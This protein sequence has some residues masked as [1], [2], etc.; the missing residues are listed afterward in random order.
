MLQ[1]FLAI[2]LLIVS[3][4]LVYYVGNLLWQALRAPIEK[5]VERRRAE[6][7]MERARRGDRHLENGSL[8]AA[9]REYEGALCPYP[10]RD[11][12]VAR[13]LFNHHT[14]LLSRFIAAADHLQGERVRLMSLAKADRLFQERNALQRR[15]L[16]LV[17]S[18]SRR[19]LQEVERELRSNA[20]ELRGALASLT[21]EITVTQ[22]RARYH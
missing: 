19:R 22:D 17:N 8:K 12:D 14:G 4:A 18:G 16:T 2:V 3:L 13:A 9:L 7:Y 10:A 5:L 11:N 1:Q 6:M 15:Y 21:A 20:K